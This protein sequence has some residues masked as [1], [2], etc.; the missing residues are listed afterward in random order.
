MLVAK[1]DP[2]DEL[3]YQLMEFALLPKVGVMVPVP[4]NETGVALGAPGIG[5]IVTVTGS[6]AVVLSQPVVA[7]RLL[8]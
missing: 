7:L 2:P 8:R 1:G 3:L 5:F 6:L 4:Q